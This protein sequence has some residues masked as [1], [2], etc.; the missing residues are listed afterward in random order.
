MLRRGEQRVFEVEDHALEVID[1]ALTKT[2]ADMHR[3][4]MVEHAGQLFEE[5][6]YLMTPKDLALLLD[7]LQVFVNAPSR[8]VEQR[9]FGLTAASGLSIDVLKQ[10][11]ALTRERA[12]LGP[13]EVLPSGPRH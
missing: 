10:F 5:P 1:E 2:S 3:T 9:S 4:R 11:A 12:A 13:H 7:R 8:I 6:L